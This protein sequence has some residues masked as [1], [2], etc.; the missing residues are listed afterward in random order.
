MIVGLGALATGSGA[1]FSSATLS[2]TATS[3]STMEVYTAGNLSVSRGSSD[4]NSDYADTIDNPSDLPAAYVSGNTTNS[5]LSVKVATQNTSSSKTLGYLLK[6]SNTSGST[7]NVGVGFDS[8][9]DEVG[10]ESETISQS[11]VV[12]A[13]EFRTNDDDSSYNLSETTGVTDND[14]ISGTSASPD[15]PSNHA[16]IP[17]GEDLAIDLT[18]D[19][20]DSLVSDINKVANESGPRF[21]VGD[22]VLLVDAITFG[23]ETTN[24]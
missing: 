24:S 11:D 18:M 22:G 4:W 10:T 8:F 9:G 5:D 1:V 16:A 15:S 17:T 7:V 3:D 12:D 23:T 20:S 13:Y 2:N 21:E 6:V 14:D 19:P